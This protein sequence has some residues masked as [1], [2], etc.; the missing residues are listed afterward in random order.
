MSGRC[1]R[2]GCG[3]WT[4]DRRRLVT[5]AMP[6]VQ[7]YSHPY[8]TDAS[9]FLSWHPSPLQVVV[10]LCDVCALALGAVDIAMLNEITRESEQ[11]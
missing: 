10:V 2:V 3:A 11:P 9:Q 1:Q 5:V 6:F 4:N 7:P 8:G